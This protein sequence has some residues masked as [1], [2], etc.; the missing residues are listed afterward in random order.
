MLSIGEIPTELFIYAGEEAVEMLT[1]VCEQ[2]WKTA[3]YWKRLM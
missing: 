3:Q 2:I 1:A